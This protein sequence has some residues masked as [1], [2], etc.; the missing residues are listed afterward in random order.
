MLQNPAT[1]RITDASGAIFLLRRSIAQTPETTA[2]DWKEVQFE[3]NDFSG[4][5]SPDDSNPIQ[6]IEIQAQSGKA[7]AFQIHWA[8]INSRNKPERLPVPVQTYKAALTTRLRGN[9]TFYVGDFRPIGSPSD[10]LPYK[11]VVPYTVNTIA[12]NIDSHGAASR[13]LAIKCLPTN[14]TSGGRQTT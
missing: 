9:Y 7:C 10:D 12:G 3:W 8:A 4:T 14:I 1:M 6:A 5:G 11:G 2:A 13:S